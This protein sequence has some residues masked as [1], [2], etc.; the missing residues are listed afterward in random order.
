MPIARVRV[1]AA[2]QFAPKALGRPAQYSLVGF[3]KWFIVSASQL[4]AAS[5]LCHFCFQN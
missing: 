2:A 4:G 1:P 5:G 3:A